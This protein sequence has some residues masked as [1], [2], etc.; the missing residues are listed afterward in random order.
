MTHEEARDTL[1]KLYTQMIEAEAAREF[2]R[3]RQLAKQ[4]LRIAEL[5]ALRGDY[6][7][8]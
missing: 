2:K 5:L 7:Y 1:A 3:L 4:V 6:S 8:M